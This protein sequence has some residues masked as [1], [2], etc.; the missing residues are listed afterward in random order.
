MIAWFI[1]GL[2]GRRLTTRYPHSPEPPPPAHRGRALLDPERCRPQDGAPCVSVCLPGAL[3]LDDDGAVELDAG[4]CIACGLC[5][6]A[7]PEEALAIDAGAELAVTDR[8]TLVVKAE[9]RR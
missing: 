6:A 2:R 8:A 5:V 7:C 1:K 3:R 4:R 9:G